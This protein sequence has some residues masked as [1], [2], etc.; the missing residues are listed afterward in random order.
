MG[1]LVICL[2]ICGLVYRNPHSTWALP[3]FV[4]LLFKKPFM[5]I[6]M[7]P[8]NKVMV[9]STFPMPDLDSLG[10]NLA[11]SAIYFTLDCFKKYWQFLVSGDL[12]CQSFVTPDVIFSLTRVPHAR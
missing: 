7:I 1:D 12:D 4:V 9:K 3:A 6:D 8:A 11:D 5:V 2:E 10:H